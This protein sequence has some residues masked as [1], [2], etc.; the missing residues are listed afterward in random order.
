MS[1]PRLAEILGV[2]IDEVFTLRGEEGKKCAV[3]GCGIFYVNGTSESEDFYDLMY[4]INNPEA[5]VRK[6]K[7]RWTKHDV[8]DAKAMVRLFRNVVCIQRSGKELLFEQQFGNPDMTVTIPADSPWL[9]S[10]RVGETV[11]LK[12]ILKAKPIE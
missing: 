1:K 3:D 11:E 8:E 12:E 9:P 2:E 10:L 5:I 4:I 7:S 6:P